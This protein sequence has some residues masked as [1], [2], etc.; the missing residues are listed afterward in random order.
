MM[1][2][3]ILK[4]YVYIYIWLNILKNVANESVVKRD[5]V[6]AD[7]V[8]RDTVSVDIVKKRKSQKGG[9]HLDPDKKEERGVD[10]WVQEIDPNTGNAYYYNKKTRESVW[11]KSDIPKDELLLDPDKKEERGVGNWV[12]MVGEDSKAFYYNTKTRETV[13][14]I[15]DIPQDEK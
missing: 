9:S 4:K 11:F 15:S 1:I 12:H 10:N 14:Y 2:I 6:S 8:K 5:T 7:T 13:L 3:R